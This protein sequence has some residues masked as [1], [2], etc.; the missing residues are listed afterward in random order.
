MAF[1]RYSCT[2]YDDEYSAA[3][4]PATAR[5]SLVFVLLGRFD[6]RDCPGAMAAELMLC[7]VR[8]E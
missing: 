2:A 1:P 8:V 3:V 7:C 4:R 6:L 5:I